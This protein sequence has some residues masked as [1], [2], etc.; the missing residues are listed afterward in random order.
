[1]RRPTA[2]GIACLICAA[3]LG[4]AAPMHQPDIRTFK[5]SIHGFAFVNSFRGSSLP[6]SLGGLEHK[7]GA[8]DRYGLCGGMSFAAADFFLAGRSIPTQDQPPV[9]GTKL[10]TYINK[11]QIDSL[12]ENMALIGEFGRCMSAPDAG[13][14]GLRT[15]TIGALDPIHRTLTDAQ[16]VILGLVYVRHANNRDSTAP[17]GTP[18]ENHQ[19]LATSISGENTALR[20]ITV[21]DPNYPKRD[22]V[23]VDCRATITDAHCL[24]PITGHM[25]PILG[26]E[27]TQRAGR[28]TIPVRTLFAMPY[29]PEIPPQNLK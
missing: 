20:T 9:K 19:V 24:A 26:V 15:L 12:G 18:W 6:I 29:T 11:R 25:I 21:Y 28:T 3:L 4:G 22:T 14:F 5:P 23:T 7:L 8:P 16:P 1:M 10:Y 27:C 13:L 17:T 2:S